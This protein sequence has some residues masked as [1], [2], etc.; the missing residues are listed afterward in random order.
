MIDNLQQKIKNFIL[1]TERTSALYEDKQKQLDTNQRKYLKLFEDLEEVK[2]ANLLLEKCNI[3]S[4]ELIKKEV[5]SLVTSA[6]VSVFEDNTFKFHVD[7]ISRRNQVEAE[8]SV[9]SMMGERYTAGDIMNSRGGGV[10]DIVATALRIVLMELLKIDGPL[11]LDEP[12]R[13][14]SAKYMENLGKFL[15]TVSQKFDR[16]I[17]LITHNEKLAEYATRKFEVNLCPKTK[18]S[19]INQI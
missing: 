12:C 3:A 2:A 5:E 13:M 14:V 10:V 17:I 4:R 18:I 11:I 16:Q 19:V 8:F 7:F 15:H 6:L 9:S 1:Y